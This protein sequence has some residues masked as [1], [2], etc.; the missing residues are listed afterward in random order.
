MVVV[1]SAGVGGSV[2]AGMDSPA[3]PEL[4]SEIWSLW[5]GIDSP[6]GLE[7]ISGDVIALPQW[8]NKVIRAQVLMAN[9]VVI[10]C[11]KIL[12]GHANIFHFYEPND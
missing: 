8:H 12:E 11:V 6:A 10:F 4:I 5:T 3:G 1:A 9:K 7:S 2:W